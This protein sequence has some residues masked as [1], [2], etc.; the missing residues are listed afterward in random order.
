MIL[1][2]SRQRWRYRRQRLQS[3]MANQWNLK[4]KEYEMLNSQYMSPAYTSKKRRSHCAVRTTD[5]NDCYDYLFCNYLRNT[6]LQMKNSRSLISRVALELAP[7]A[8]P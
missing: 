2:V 4:K 3:R 8:K 5:I 6:P 7:T 1:G